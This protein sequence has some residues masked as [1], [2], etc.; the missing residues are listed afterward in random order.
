V[1]DD[2]WGTRDTLIG[3]RDVASGGFNFTAYGDA[4]DNVFTVT[5]KST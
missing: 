4:Q 2:G 5:A 1:A 3:V